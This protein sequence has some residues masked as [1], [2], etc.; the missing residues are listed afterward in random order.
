MNNKGKVPLVPRGRFAPTI[1]TNER[2]R[3]TTRQQVASQVN[4]HKENETKSDTRPD[5]TLETT[6]K[7]EPHIQP[8]TSGHKTNGNTNNYFQ[9]DSSDEETTATK[10]NPTT[11][12]RSLSLLPVVLSDSNKEQV[13]DGV[14]DENLKQRL[15]TESSKLTEEKGW[16]FIQLPP[17]LPIS[18]A[19][20]IQKK[21]WPSEK[22]ETVD[23]SASHEAKL[24]ELK[25]IMSQKAKESHLHPDI[26]YLKSCHL[27]RLRVFRSGKIEVVMHGMTCKVLQGVETSFLEKGMQVDWEKGLLS[28]LGDIHHRWICIPQVYNDYHLNKAPVAHSKLIKEEEKF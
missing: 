12:G 26:R 18:D 23:E 1:P 2:R 13:Q 28:E 25:Y 9:L 6:V 19:M 24:E 20:E 10:G 27:G 14:Y 17:I 16:F 15:P 3:R 5:K 7:Q 11:N 22:E 4:Q 8:I 21:D